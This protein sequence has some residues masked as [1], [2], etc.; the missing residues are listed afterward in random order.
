MEN[1]AIDVGFG[2][3]KGV[4]GNG[5]RIN[6]PS[7]IG[8]FH[9][10]AYDSG[11]A[12]GNLA[13]NYKSKKSFVGESALKQSV[14]RATV[15]TDRTVGEEGMTLLAAAMA[16][17]TDRSAINTNL[18]VGLPVRNYEMLKNQYL[19]QTQTL[20]NVE[21]LTLTGVPVERKYI[22][23]GEAKVLPQPF[24]AFFNLILDD[25]GGFVREDL[26]MGKVG[27]ID[28]GYNTLDLAR[29]DRLEYINPRSTSFAGQGIFNAFQT[30]S[31]EIYR[32]HKVEIPPERIEAV[33]RAG[34][35]KISGNEISI[36][37]EMETAFREAAAQIISRVKSLWPDRWELD[38]ILLAGGGAILLAK[39]L[40]AEFGQQA[41]IAP[42][43]AFANV[44]GYLKFARRLW[45]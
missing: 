14:P 36:H 2:E 42:E 4:A 6:F 31:S 7:I 44:N 35:L 28:V 23:V 11:M 37:T 13:I 16:L 9:P 41:I 33:V 21:L 12:E 26:A 27:I 5:R 29:A 38:L 24:G 3:T 1:M 34:K 18:V 10:V 40:L 22:S 17:L 32:K 43:P 45:K 30:L 19:Q 25:K 20:H 39:Y 15:D 8:D